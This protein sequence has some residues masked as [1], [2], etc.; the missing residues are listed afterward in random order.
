MFEHLN[1]WEFKGKSFSYVYWNP[2]RIKKCRHFL[3]IGEKKKGKK[4]KRKCHRQQS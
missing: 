3:A 4:N 2:E 1:S